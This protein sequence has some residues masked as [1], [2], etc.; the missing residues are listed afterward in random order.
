MNASMMA[1]PWRPPP[2]MALPPPPSPSPPTM[3]LPPPP[4][5]SPPRSAASSTASAPSTAALDYASL[6]AAACRSLI[7]GPPING[8]A[9]RSSRM[10]WWSRL[11][12]TGSGTFSDA[13]AKAIDDSWQ[14]HS[15]HDASVS[16]RWDVGPTICAKAANWH[17][18]WFI[19]AHIPHPEPYHQPACAALKNGNHRPFVFGEMR[20]P[21]KWC[22]SWIAFWWRHRTHPHAPLWAKRYYAPLRSAPD[23]NIF[24]QRHASEACELQMTRWFCGAARQR[25]G[26]RQHLAGAAPGDARARRVRRQVRVRGRRRAGGRDRPA[27]PRASARAV[28]VRQAGGDAEAGCPRAQL[29]DPAKAPYGARDRGGDG[30]GGGGSAIV[31]GEGDGGGGSAIVGGERHGS[32][33]IDAFMVAA[34]AARCSAHASSAA[35]A[36]GAEMRTSRLPKTRL[37]LVRGR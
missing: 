17:Q 20:E 31:G 33:I 8:P 10:V 16:F 7:G 5:P 25:D 2:T 26:A 21:A 14:K 23:F 6:D 18:P 4:S 11:P 36:G 13:I 29:D 9:N 37:D 35:A 3:A 12:R 19:E 1:L 34:H 32:A 22:W 27:P 15:E 24:A 30:D 28:V